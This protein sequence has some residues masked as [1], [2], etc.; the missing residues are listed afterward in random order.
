MR[1]LKK[2]ICEVCNNVYEHDYSQKSKYC[3]QKCRGIAYRQRNIIGTE[4]ID[5]VVCKVCELKF[6][7]IN[8]DHISQ[9]NLTCD[10][11]DSQF[12][13]PRTS[14]KTKLNKNTLE[15][16]MNEDFSKKLSYSHTLENYKNKYGESEG[17]KKFNEMKKNKKYRNGKQSYIDKYGEIRGREI[18]DD[19]QSKKRITLNNMIIKYGNVDGSKRYEKWKNLQKIR[20]LLSFFVEKYGHEVGLEKWL[21]KNNKISIS[22]SKIDR[23]DRDDFKNYI[24]DVNKYTRISLRLNQLDGIELRGQK[25]NYDLDHIMSKIDGFKN[26]IPP[27][28]IGHISNLRIIPSYEN[29]KKQHKSELDINELLQ[30][31]DSDQLYKNLVLEINNGNN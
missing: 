21:N 2:N 17:E 12:K 1:S 13:S 7:E 9:H 16:L 14:E 10:E 28:I 25:N 20:N 19:V 24:F 18:Y 5:F 8:N 11:Y 6:K 23:V 22:N 29:R 15:K 4:G 26:N 30:K 3:S 31:Y 27:H